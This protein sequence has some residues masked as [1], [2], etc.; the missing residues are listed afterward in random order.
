MKHEIFFFRRP[1]KRVIFVVEKNRKKKKKKKKI[2][3]PPASYVASLQYSLPASFYRNNERRRS[4]TIWLFLFYSLS[5]VDDG[6]RL[7]RV[8]SCR[9]CIVGQP[10]VDGLAGR[11]E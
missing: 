3:V 10:V 2:A 5:V 9:V 1:T 7:R 8:V 6:G 11:L 4:K